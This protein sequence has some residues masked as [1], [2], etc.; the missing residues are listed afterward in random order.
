MAYNRWRNGQVYVG[1][2]LKHYGV[3]GM[4]WGVHK[5][6]YYKR[7]AEDMAYRPEVR[8]EY[9]KRFKSTVNKIQEKAGKKFAKYE[10]EYNKRQRKADAAYEKAQK[11]AYGF[12]SNQE[13]AN[14]AFAA[15]SK[16]QYKANKILYKEKRW[17]EHMVK[18]YK[19]MKLDLDP[20]TA[21][22]GEEIIRRTLA[23]SQTMYAADRKR[24]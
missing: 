9:R 7:H 2:E 15:A 21:K 13:R 8:A 22:I 24:R 11:K 5:A 20:E 6:R 3:L 19:D 18:A 17:Y 23:Q 4:R 14:K 10:R 1:G 12:F 16:K